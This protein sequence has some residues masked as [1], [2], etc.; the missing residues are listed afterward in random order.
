MNVD[1]Y[2]NFFPIYADTMKEARSYEQ[3]GKLFEWREPQTPGCNLL[4]MSG[5]LPV[6]KLIGASHEEDRNLS[7]QKKSLPAMTE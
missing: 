5:V 3:G 4:Q 6:R 1:P 7:E 2:G